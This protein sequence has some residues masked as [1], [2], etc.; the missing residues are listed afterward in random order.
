MPYISTETLV[1]AALLVLVVIG[2]QHYP[3]STSAPAT[4]SSTTGKASK[5]KSKK[6][7]GGAGGGADAVDATSGPPEAPA[8]A[9]NGDE[10][11]AEPKKKLLAEKLLPK[12]RKTKV[13]DMLAPEDRAPTIARVMKVTPS[14]SSKPQASA[15][16]PIPSP[17]PVSLAP[18]AG[19]SAQPL[20]KP[21]ASP[22]QKVAKFED[23]Y[24]SASEPEEP[25]PAPVKGKGK[26][27]DDEGW[28]VV[29]SK[30]KKP[31]SVNI[32]SSSQPQ[33]QSS[34]A[35]PLPVATSIQKKNAKKA[36]QKK[37]QR[38]AEEADRLKRLAT[39]KKDLERQ[40]INELYS[41]SKKSSG[42]G[43]PTVGATASVTANG[44]LV[45]E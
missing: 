28:D 20:G 42:R 18:P 6:K 26:K 34:T 1:G 19:T 32:G 38:E 40:R 41:T 33:P 22:E 12:Q 24:A 21:I 25:A 39:H 13:D 30:K 14:A 43:S 36:E 17:E 7:K 2:I 16:A 5:K 44:K 4:S 45:W 3:T 8:P 29:V 15:W 27:K 35:L 11:K 37:A 10:A 31:I 9:V 23:D